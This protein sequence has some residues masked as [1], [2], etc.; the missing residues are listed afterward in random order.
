MWL[1]LTLKVWHLS[2]LIKCALGHRK[3]VFN[4]HADTLNFNFKEWNYS[5][6]YSLKRVLITLLSKIMSGLSLCFRLKKYRLV[7]WMNMK[8]WPKYTLTSKQFWKLTTNG[9]EWCNFKMR[10]SITKNINFDERWRNLSLPFW[11]AVLCYYNFLWFSCEK[12]DVKLK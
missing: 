7:Y 11:F 2:F 8:D 1:S 10:L 4:I 6:H 5:Q 12:L 9:L 3:W